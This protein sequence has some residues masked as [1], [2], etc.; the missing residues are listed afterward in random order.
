MYT[1]R[2]TMY[3]PFGQDTWDYIG[4]IAGELLYE[5]YHITNELVET[6]DFDL[7]HHES[8]EIG[9]TAYDGLVSSSS[10]VVPQAYIEK[11]V[12]LGKR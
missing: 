3:R 10:T 5:D 7:F 12:P 6:L 8:Y 2:K 4:N 9:A 11:F 1:Y